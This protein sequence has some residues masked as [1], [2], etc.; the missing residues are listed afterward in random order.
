MASDEAWLSLCSAGAES[1]ARCVDNRYFALVLDPEG[2][3]VGAGYNG[4][5]SGLANCPD[6][7]PKAR[8]EDRCYAVHA[9][10][11]ALLYSDRTA[12]QGGTIYINGVPCLECAKLIAGSGLARVVLD[13]RGRS[14]RPDKLSGLALMREAGLTVVVQP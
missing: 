14:M 12:R 6:G 3:V 10:A 7:C 8:G 5:P 13:Q 9:E 1:M 2:R 4:T 11:N